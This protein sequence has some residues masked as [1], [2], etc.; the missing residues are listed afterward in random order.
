[1]R[2]TT[3]LLKNFRYA[4]KKKRPYSRAVKK[5]KILSS[6]ELVQKKKELFPQNIKRTGHDILYMVKTHLKYSVQLCMDDTI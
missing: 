2:L 6:V 3:H 1:M 5:R 4:C